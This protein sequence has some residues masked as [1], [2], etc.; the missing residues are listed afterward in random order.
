MP[1]SANE[2]IL[3]RLVIDGVVDSEQTA[4][5]I[6]TIAKASPCGDDPGWSDVQVAYGSVV[7]DLTIAT[8]FGELIPVSRD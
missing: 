7:E 2:F 4:I 1:L 5:A 3:T 6:A 8:P